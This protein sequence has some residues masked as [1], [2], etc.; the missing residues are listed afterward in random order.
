MSSN[1]PA[2]LSAC[3]GILLGCVSVFLFIEKKIELKAFIGMIVPACV[4]FLIG[5]GM[6]L[7]KN[8]SLSSS[9]TE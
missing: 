8:R 5:A 3:I 1:N 7:K 9:T 2:I 4:L 6:I